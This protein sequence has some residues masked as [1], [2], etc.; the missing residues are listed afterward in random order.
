MNMSYPGE[1]CEGVGGEPSWQQGSQGKTG[2]AAAQ[3]AGEVRQDGAGESAG[4]GH[5]TPCG[6]RK[7][8]KGLSSDFH[9]GFQN[10][11]GYNL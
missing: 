10:T 2:V 5:T 4:P 7:P 6:K 1:E 3:R 9:H 8:L 11:F